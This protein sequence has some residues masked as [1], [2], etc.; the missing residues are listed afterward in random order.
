MDIKT[1]L[2]ID[3]ETYNTL[4]MRVYYKKGG[5][6]YFTYKTEPRGI[7]FS[8]SPVTV[9]SDRGFETRSFMMFGNGAWKGLLLEMARG[10]KKKL[11]AIREK[12]FAVDTDKVV[13]LFKAGDKRGIVNMVTE[14]VAA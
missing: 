8:L 10:N 14:A 3:G 4:E 11:A 13:E 1:E 12:V 9:S 6:N 2:K 5:M 7:Y